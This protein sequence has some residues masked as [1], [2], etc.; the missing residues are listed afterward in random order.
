MDATDTTDFCLNTGV[1]LCI[2]D[3]MLDRFVYGRVERIS[4]EAPIPVLHITRETTM[5]GGAGNVALNL[6]GLGAEA[7]L[8]SLIGDDEAGSAVR[9]HLGAFAKPIGLALLAEP[10]R[11][12]TLKTRFIAGSQQMLRTDHETVAPPKDPAR[13]IAA[14]V[15]A[16]DGAGAIIL[17]DYG[18]GMLDATI[19]GETIALAAKNKIPIIVDPKGRDFSRYRGADIITPNRHELADATDMDVDTN[20]AVIA[21]ARHIITNAGINAVLVTLSAE[22]M[23]YVTATDATHI[24]ARAR[25]V[26]DVSGAGDTVVATLAAGIAAGMSV[27]TAAN[28]A[29]VAASIVVAKLGTAVVFDTELRDA[30]RH[31]T[32]GA[33]EARVME[34]DAALAC[35]T[36]WRDAGQTI[37]FTNGCFDLLHPGHVSLLAQAKSHC[38]RLVVGL[39]SDASVRRLKGETRPVQNETARA[40]VLAS[41]GDVDLVV[42]FG[43]DTPLALIEAIGPDVLVKGADYSVDQVVGRE[44]VEA[45]GG[46]VVLAELLDGHSTTGTIKRLNLK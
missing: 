23:S 13:V 35:I 26:F 31:Q 32:I 21:A 27:V 43:E 20:D 38:D 39:N 7:R 24:S 11:E 10:G 14:I 22:G 6:A 15:K 16:A 29:N 1:V 34:R 37:G 25:D 40:Q 17:S 46:R 12:T 9:A 5:P 36:E 2:G 44:A 42:L 41:M 8:V 19:I 4:P 18:K 28:L 30:L 33:A 45:R 3:L